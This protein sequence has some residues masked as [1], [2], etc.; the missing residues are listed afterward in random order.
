MRT[1]L[2][3][4]AAVVVLIVALVAFIG[5]TWDQPEVASEATPLPEGGLQE[6]PGNGQ[7]FQEIPA[8]MAD[9]P[10]DTEAEESTGPE[11]GA[12]ELASADITA[13]K[14]PA[15]A[16]VTVS[17]SETGFSPATVTVAAGT[18]VAFRNDGQAAHWPASDSHPT[19]QILPEFDAKAGLGTGETY[20]HTFTKAG[21]WRCHDHLMPQH[22]CT[23]VVQ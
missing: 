16:G 17:M 6:L 19:H 14:T 4:G 5:L 22:T 9:G 20:A 12:D 11:S 21:T 13:A 10:G 1:S 18:T 8:T 3:V 2:V 7:Y 23:I 15:V